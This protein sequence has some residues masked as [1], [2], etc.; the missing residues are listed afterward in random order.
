VQSLTVAEPIL[1]Q[2]CQNQFFL[3]TIIRHVPKIS[4]EIPQLTIA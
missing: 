4:G 3:E 2:I 1:P